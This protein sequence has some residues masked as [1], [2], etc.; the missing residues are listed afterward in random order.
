MKGYPMGKPGKGKP[1]MGKG[2][3]PMGKGKP[4]MGMK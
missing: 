4:P 3:P 1:P 2:K